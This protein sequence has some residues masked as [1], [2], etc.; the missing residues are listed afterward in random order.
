M[1]YTRKHKLIVVIIFFILSVFCFTEAG[2]AAEKFVRKYSKDIDLTNEPVNTSVGRYNIKADMSRPATP[3]RELVFR[4]HIERNGQP[5]EL[6]NGTL[7]FNMAMDMGL[8]QARLQK[9]A[10]GYSAKVTLPKC[11]FGGQRWF[12]KLS[13]EEGNFSAEKVFLFDMEK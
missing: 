2:H 12:L 1:M 10:T 8:Y 5:V 11:I 4:F 3:F 13:I 9:A 6:D 7:K